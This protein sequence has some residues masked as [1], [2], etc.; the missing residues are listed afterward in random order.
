M[1]LTFAILAASFLVLS[2]APR[3]GS[4]AALLE[5]LRSAK[6]AGADDAAMAQTVHAAK[7]TD[8]LDDAVIEELQSEGAGPLTLEE[9]ERQRE[10]TRKLAP[11]AQAIQLFEAPPPP[12]ADEQSRVLEKVRAIALQYTSSLPDFLATETVRRYVDNKLSQV[13]KPTDTLKL[14]V[15]YSDKGERYKMLEID[16]RPTN[17]SLKEV[18]GFTSNGEFGSL[19]KWIFMPQSAT[20]F[21]WE[22]WTNLRGRPTYVFSYRIDKANSHYGMNWRMFLKHYSGNFAQKG[23]VYVDRETNQVMRF[24]AEAD[25][26][27][28]DWPIVRT[29]E[30]LDYDYAMIGG[31]S[32]LLPVRVDTR[33]VLKGQQSRNVV[34][35]VNYRKFSGE[36][37]VNFE[38]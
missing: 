19:L 3:D 17:K 36:A 33:V 29:P 2:A 30:V 23:V 27:P 22:H 15:A 9:L 14:D 16:G 4:T 12:T 1:R 21:Q 20:R 32:F 18:G 25:Q 7:L 28:G 31:R 38:K 8:R 11:P 35:F 34:E 10:L 37:T 24:S 5:A 13:W 26:I 6:K